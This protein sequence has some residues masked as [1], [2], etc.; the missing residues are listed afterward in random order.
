MVNFGITVHAISLGYFD[1]GMIADVPEE[2]LNELKSQVPLK[3]L[4]SP[5][6]IFKTIE[7]LL[8]E[9]GGYMTGQTDSFEWR[10]ICLILRI[11]AHAFNSSS[12]ENASLGRDDPGYFLFLSGTGFRLSHSI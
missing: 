1:R 3:R 9:E 8:S 10:F 4:G 6:E 2:Q 7:W 12:V 5:K 11:F